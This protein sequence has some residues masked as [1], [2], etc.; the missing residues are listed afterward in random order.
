MFLGSAELSDDFARKAD[1]WWLNCSVKADSRGS[2][3]QSEVHWETA[4]L[5]M[6]QMWIMKGQQTR[7][8]IPLTLNMSGTLSGWLMELLT[9]R[10]LAGAGC[11]DLCPWQNEH[12][13]V[14]TAIIRSEG[15]CVRMRE[16]I[17]LLWY[18]ASGG[19]SHRDWFLNGVVTRCPGTQI[20]LGLAWSDTTAVLPPDGWSQG[21]CLP[22]SDGNMLLVQ[23]TIMELSIP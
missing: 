3:F 15:V 12:G 1:W 5:K 16:C 17:H 2:E 23:I 8:S 19:L 14:M 7:S 20:H 18:C 11:T 4:V 22:G 6:H 9:S 21:I 13:R 10:S